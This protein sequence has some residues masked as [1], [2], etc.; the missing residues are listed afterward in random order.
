MK[1]ILFDKIRVGDI[2]ESTRIFSEYLLVLIRKIYTDPSVYRS[3]VSKF[4]LILTHSKHLFP[5][6]YSMKSEQLF[7][8]F[9]QI[10]EK[11]LYCHI[12]RDDSFKIDN[13][14]NE[15]E[16]ELANMIN[17]QICF[18]KDQSSNYN[19]KKDYVPKIERSIELVPILR[20][21]SPSYTK[22]TIINKKILRKFKNFLKEKYSALSSEIYENI[23]LIFWPKFIKENLLP[24]MKYKDINNREVEFK[25]FNIKYLIWLFNKEG[26]IILYDNFIEQYG[27]DT[28]NEMVNAYNI[29]DQHEIDQLQFYLNHLGKGFHN[30]S[31][32]IK[33]YKDDAPLNPK[34]YEKMYQMYDDYIGKDF[35]I[36]MDDLFSY[37]KDDSNDFIR[38]NDRVREID[39]ILFDTLIKSPNSSDREE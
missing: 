15:Y 21:F 30:E 18:M 20:N 36:K 7:D 28:L 32:H 31:L 23:D 19:N 17:T 22:K 9:V 37:T 8:S 25:S 4:N 14:Y 1:L 6:D 13:C 24:P 12:I 5:L 26:A 16:N 34:S 3:I 27:K 35:D 33:N 10:F 2:V 39:Y 11:M 38:N 29:I